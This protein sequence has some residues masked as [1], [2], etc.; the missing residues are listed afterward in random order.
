MSLRYSL[1]A[2]LDRQVV[3]GP[4]TANF[5]SIRST[6]TLWNNFIYDLDDPVHGD[7]KQQDE[8]RLPGEPT[9]GVTG[10]QLHPLEQH[11]ACFT[12]PADGVAQCSPWLQIARCG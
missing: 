8:S 6:I 11:S 7:Q 10:F 1:S 2:R 4:L 9:G 3:P 5:H 12:L